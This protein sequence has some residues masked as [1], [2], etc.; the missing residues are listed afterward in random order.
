MRAVDLLNADGVKG[1]FELQLAVADGET[2]TKAIQNTRLTGYELGNLSRM[3]GG[4]NADPSFSIKNALCT[5]AVRNATPNGAS[6][7]F[8]GECTALHVNIIGNVAGPNGTVGSCYWQLNSTL[9]NSKALPIKVGS[10]KMPRETEG[11][12]GG[13]GIIEIYIGVVY[14]IGKFLRYVFQ[15][16]SQRMIW[17]ELPNTQLLNDLCNGIYI[18]RIREDMENEYRLYYEFVRI[19]RRPDL[20]FAICKTE[21]VE[22]KKALTNSMS[23]SPGLADSISRGPHG[24]VRDSPP[25]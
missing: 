17:E 15:D 16:S 20:L 4:G 24:N 5:S 13:Y 22:Q 2:S 9:E 10:S 11:G 12:G 1:T 21:G 23:S 6:V 18:A 7:T 8:V 25:P 3:I 14:T 19:F